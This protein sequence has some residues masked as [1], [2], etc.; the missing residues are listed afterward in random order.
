LFIVA[1]LLLSLLPLP[2]AAFTAATAT[3]QQQDGVPAP[4][5]A[6]QW[7][8]VGE[9]AQYTPATENLPAPATLTRATAPAAE[10][11]TPLATDL[12]A[13]PELV[14]PAEPVEIVLGGELQTAQVGTLPLALQAGGAGAEEPL[15]GRVQMLQSEQAADLSP[16]HFAFGLQLKTAAAA[17]QPVGA[18]AA[19]TVVIDYS[20]IP[21]AQVSDV[22]ERLT[23]YRASGCTVAPAAAGMEIAVLD[24]AEK[25]ILS[26][27]PG[28][29]VCTEWQPLLV[30]NDRAAQ[31][32]VAQL[33][34][35][36]VMAAA[37]PMPVNQE[38]TQEQTA[39]S[40]HLYLP[41]IQGAENAGGNA[42]GAQTAMPP[43]KQAA[44]QLYLPLVA[45]STNPRLPAIRP[46]QFL[47]HSMCWARAQAGR[48]VTTAPRRSMPSMTTR[49][50]CLPGRSPPA[51]PLPCRPPP[52][53]LHPP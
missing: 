53:G 45:D 33:T 42:P 32:L 5:P 17:G 26:A 43:V 20:R 37:A 40:P 46:A 10:T 9:R 23:L 3:A 28:R 31:Q 38:Q 52:P 41:F 49:S 30:H 8:E 34:A 50:A 29:V 7:P 11:Q 21:L 39:A 4:E 22:A 44:A 27:A 1:A 15:L 14:L 18:S 16:L 25:D 36:A 13:I 51:T 35:V 6:P 48:A 2:A 12:P 24:A 19:L 47:T